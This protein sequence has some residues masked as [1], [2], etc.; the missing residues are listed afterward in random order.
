MLNLVKTLTRLGDR[1]LLVREKAALELE[2]FNFTAESAEIATSFITVMFS[3]QRWEDRFGA[4]L[5]CTSL[6]K[7]A[8][9]FTSEFL[10]KIVA[11][12][13]VPILMF[14]PEFRVRNQVGA[15]LKAFLSRCDNETRQY[16]FNRLKDMLVLNIDQTFERDQKQENSKIEADQANDKKM[17]DTEGWKS[18]DTSMNCLKNLIEAIGKNIFDLDLSQILA[19]VIKSAQHLNRFVKEIAFQI[20]DVLFQ[21]AKDNSSDKQMEIYQATVPLISDS[22]TD[23]WP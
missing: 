1:Q 15:L 2:N 13:K 14:D 16:Q 12:Q 4:I 22:L 18:L 23:T 7:K 3:S 19:I 5:G 17:H 6:A 21:A 9:T 8:M 11:E 20:I 10:L